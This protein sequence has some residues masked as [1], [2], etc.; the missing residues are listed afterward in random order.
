MTT[1]AVRRGGFDWQKQG[2]L[3]AVSVAIVA[4]GVFLVVQLFRNPDLF[5]QTLMKALGLGAVYALIALGFVLIFKATQTVNFA[6]GALAMC[7]ALFVSFMVADDHIPFTTWKNPISDIGGPSWLPW[8]LST[9]VALAFAGALGLLI[10][11]LAIRPMIGEPLFSVAVITLGL[12]A[13]FRT[14]A[15]DTVK[16]QYRSLNVPWTAGKGGFT[17]GDAFINWSYIAAMVTAAIAFVAVYFFFRSRT[18][19]AMR[20]VAYDQEAAMAQGINVGRVFA[21]AWAA[22]AILAAI[23]GIFAAQPPIDQTGAVQVS[24]QFI[25]FRALP[26]VI[27]GGLDSVVGALAGGLIVGSAEIFAGQ[28]AA[29]LTDQLGAGYPLIVPYVVMI[30]G[31]LVRPYGLFGTPEIRRV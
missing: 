17:V 14:F 9:L 3:I 5:F 18:G 15:N 6:Q 31:L 12:E 8:I 24:T 7:G 30:I 10:E 19:V 23:G 27:L 16:S 1:V 29:G 20:A 25:A 11:R 13:F 21:L 28:Y 22:G 2:P 26:A 4:I